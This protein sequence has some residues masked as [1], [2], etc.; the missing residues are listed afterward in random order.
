[1]CVCDVVIPAKLRNCNEMNFTPMLKF[2][3]CCSRPPFSL[4]VSVK[5]GTSSNVAAVLHHR[6]HV[7]VVPLIVLETDV[8]SSLTV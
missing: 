8:F 4:Q 1:M 6:R 7:T 5:I 3:S 2:S